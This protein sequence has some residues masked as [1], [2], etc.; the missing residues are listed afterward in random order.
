M[1]TIRAVD[2]ARLFLLTAGAIVL[3]LI[4]TVLWHFTFASGRQVAGIIFLDQDFP[5]LLLAVVGLILLS[6]VARAG[7]FAL[8][9]ATGRIVVGLVL[10][11][12][13]W[14]W[15]GHQ[16]VFQGY[17]LSRDEEV[18]EFAAA[19]MR[20]GAIS[21]PIPPEWVAYRHA[22]F[23][24]FF[25]PFGAV[26]NW[27]AAY[28][29]LNS[30]I[31][32]AFWRLGDPNLAAPVLMAVGLIA[33]WRVAVR[34]FPE[35]PD[36][37][38]VVLLM[39]LTSTQLSVT[40]MTP[41]AMTAHF[42]F[43]M[44]WLALLLRGGVAGH[45]GAGI[46]AVAAAGLHQWHFPLIFLMPFIAWLA[47]GRRWGAMAFHSAVLVVIVIVWAKLWPAFLLEHL[48]PAADI[49]P[50]AGVGDKVGSLF[51]R[52]TDKWQPLLN[53]SRFVAWNNVLLLPLSVLGVVGMRWR[54]AIRG[55]A[56]VLPLAVG[57]FA[58][59]GL[60]LYQGYGWGFRY[61]HGFI[62]PLCLLAGFGWIR[63]RASSLAP[64]YLSVVLA[65]ATGA[66]LTVRAHDYVAPYAAS[67]R[68]IHAAHADV[69]LVD[70]RGGIFVTDLVRGEDGVPGRPMV[71]NLSMLTQAR[72]D[73]LCDRYEV[74]LFDW[75]AFRALGVRPARWSGNHE[76]KLRERMAETGCGW[77]IRAR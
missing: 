24:E 7:A 23:P 50:S 32:A 13:L 39:G 74:A 42:A 46:V 49:R 45:V 22:I 9:P 68:L 64:I 26:H 3:W 60:A 63:M 52:L 36:A 10:L 33:L 2:P 70:S 77:L 58:S 48:G 71:M 62:G 16:W 53:M 18:A 5:A 6:P 12:A 55:R 15:A 37:V 4:G 57:A 67:D 1:T 61:A 69:V 34:L 27:T 41:Y 14:S 44:V 30:A 17:S 35:R 28:L 66:F 25:S 31:R 47:L 59:L 43:N 38:W 8:P 76:T 54:E 56:I 65:V 72:L 73:A 40:A 19:Y 29:P 20:E 75:S 11:L 51:T 21:R